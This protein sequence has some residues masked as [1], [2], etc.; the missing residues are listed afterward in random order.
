MELSALVSLPEEEEVSFFF[1]FS[2]L[3]FF[4]SFFFFS[5]FFSLFSYLFF[6][7]YPLVV[8]SFS[9]LFPL[10]FIL[11]SLSLSPPLPLSF[12]K[13][14]LKKLWESLDKVRATKGSEETGSLTIALDF[15]DN[16]FI[17]SNHLEK[18]Y[19][20]DEAGA[21]KV[22]SFLFFFFGKERQ[23]QEKK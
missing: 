15:K 14:N 23:I 11:F 20:A 21:V 12:P 7:F 4:F 2:F 13:K 17:S 8:L 10:L 6:S 3:F 9:S 18:K 5:F 19:A 16:S 22:N 1:F